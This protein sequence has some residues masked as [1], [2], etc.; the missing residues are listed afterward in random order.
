MDVANLVQILI[1]IVIEIIAIVL[2]LAVYD[3]LIGFK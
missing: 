3:R 2:G 1:D